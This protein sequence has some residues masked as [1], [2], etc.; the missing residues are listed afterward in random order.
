M[1]ALDSGHTVGDIAAPVLVHRGRL[2]SLQSMIGQGFQ[3]IPSF[4]HASIDAHDTGL[5]APFPHQSGHPV[6]TDNQAV[7]AQRLI[8]PGAAIAA[9]A[10]VV[11]LADLQQQRGILSGSLAGLP[12]CPGVVARPRDV[13]VAA[14]RLYSVL[15][16][17]FPDE[18]ERFRRSS[19]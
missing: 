7:T 4:R 18:P 17:V 12:T 2:V 16:S 5:H 19:A 15:P 11:D 13:Q 6:L 1:L 8:D 3:V 10:V 14:Q 9:L